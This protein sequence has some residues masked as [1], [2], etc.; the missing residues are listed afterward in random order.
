MPQRTSRK[1]LHGLV[2]VEFR[3]S[4][5]AGRGVFARRAFR[6]GDVVVSYAPK[7]RRLPADTD[8]ARVAA[9]TK[10]TLLSEGKWVIVPDTS[11]PGGWLCNHSCA[12][13]AALYSS[14]EGRIQCIRPIARGEEVT[15]FYGWV[16][17]NQPGRDPCR[18]GAAGCRRVINFD[19]TDADAVC[20]ETRT[21][22][23]EALQRRIDEYAEYLCSINQE[24]VLDTLLST[25]AA[26]R[27]R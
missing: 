5:I 20:F 9:G 24:Q 14:G 25:L 15:I 23:G 26:M 2:P 4:E 1:A 12:P 18:C 22:E 3:D 7:Q 19:V 8:V 11:E 17:R 13:N 21:A 6:A 16:T 10:L 27:R